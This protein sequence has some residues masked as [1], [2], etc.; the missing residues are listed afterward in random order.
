MKVHEKEKSLRAS[1]CDFVAESL[2]NQETRMNLCEATF[3]R[4]RF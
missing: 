1:L 2:K 3:S 4:S